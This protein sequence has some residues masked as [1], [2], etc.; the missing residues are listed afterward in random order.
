[1]FVYKQMWSVTFMRKTIKIYHDD[2]KTG[3]CACFG[4]L[5]M[6]KKQHLSFLKNV[7]KMSDVL[8]SLFKYVK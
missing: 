2:K 3:W 4:Y 8:S 7:K 6:R 5:K 1:M